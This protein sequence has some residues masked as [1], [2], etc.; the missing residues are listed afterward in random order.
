MLSGRE[1]LELRRRM[2]P[3]GTA[4]IKDFVRSGGR[5]LGIHAGAYY[6]SELCIDV[7]VGDNHADDRVGNNLGFFPGGCRGYF[8]RP[9]TNPTRVA[10]ITA[11][12][13]GHGFAVY[14]RGGGAF[15]DFDSSTPDGFAVIAHYVLDDE[16]GP[17][18][19][20]GIAV[21][22]CPAGQGACVLASSHIE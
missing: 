12:E 6:G 16:T 7:D 5:C 11:R 17:D 10:T 1:Y 14:D 3:R 8:A 13:G 22:Y 9:A 18:T 19:E 20:G 15:S 4:R 21:V 2:G